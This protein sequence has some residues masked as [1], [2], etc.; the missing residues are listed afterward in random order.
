[1]DEQPTDKQRPLCTEAKAEAMREEN[2][3]IR[4]LLER[5]GL[6]IQ[7]APVSPLHG[8]QLWWES[9]RDILRDIKKELG[10]DENL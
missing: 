2:E 5:A 10:D 9:R 6:M 1:M 8:D 7:G 3:R 4:G